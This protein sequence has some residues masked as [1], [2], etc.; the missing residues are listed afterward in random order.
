MLKTQEN[1]PLDD[2]VR[3]LNRHI[4]SNRKSI[5]RLFQIVIW[6]FQDSGFHDLFFRTDFMDLN[7][8]CIKGALALFVLVSFSGYVC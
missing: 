8:Y 7:L 6:H 5:R 3:L 2:V 1:K 4:E